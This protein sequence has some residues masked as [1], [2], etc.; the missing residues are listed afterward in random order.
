VHCYMMPNIL[1]LLLAAP[2]QIYGV[3]RSCRSDSG[4]LSL[5]SN[6]F[7]CLDLKISENLAVLKA[8]QL[9]LRDRRYIM[10]PCGDDLQF[11]LLDFV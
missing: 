4:S 2:A 8:M 7:P 1:S 11:N 9:Y 5:S 3:E 6:T 10:L